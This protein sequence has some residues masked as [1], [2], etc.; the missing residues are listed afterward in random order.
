MGCIDTRSRGKEWFSFSVVVVLTASHPG[1]ADKNTGLR[2]T[3]RG[4]DCISGTGTE[5]V[6]RGWGWGGVLL[7]G[8]VS[9]PK[10]E[11]ACNG[12]AATADRENARAGGMHEQR[13]CNLVP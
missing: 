6:F 4:V 9:K 2:E 13:A 1:G 3:S 10:S 12:I 7:E 8:P 5:A 11:V